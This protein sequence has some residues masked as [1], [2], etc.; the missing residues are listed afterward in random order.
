MK[1]L[2]TLLIVIT[3]AV[4]GLTACDTSD[5]PATTK[6]VYTMTMETPLGE[7][8]VTPAVGTHEYEE[9]VMVDLEAVPDSGWY[10]SQWEGEVQNNNA[11]S[12]RIKMDKNQTVRAVFTDQDPTIPATG[13]NLSVKVVDLQEMPISGVEVSFA[14]VDIDDFT[15][16]T[17]GDGYVV[18]SNSEITAMSRDAISEERLDERRVRGADE[19]SILEFEFSLLGDVT[20]TPS[21]ENWAFAP[22]SATVNQADAGS[23]I[24]FVGTDLLDPSYQLGG[25]VED[26]HGKGVVGAQVLLTG[27]DFDESTLGEIITDSDG[28]WGPVVVEGTVD[29]TAAKDH[30]TFTPITVQTGD[31]NLVISGEIF[32]DAVK[33]PLVTPGTISLAQSTEVT[34]NVEVD[35]NQAFLALLE[36]EHA[37][38]VS[39]YR[40][41]NSNNWE[42]IDNLY[43]DGDYINHGDDIAGDRIYSNIIDFYEEEA[44]NI[45]LKIVVN[46]AE[47]HV[48]E[49]KFHLEAASVAEDIEGK[50]LSIHEEA[51]S[52]LNEILLADPS[53]TAAESLNLL[54]NKLLDKEEITSIVQNN[55]LLQLD[56]EFIEPGDNFT[57]VSFIMVEET[58]E[59][60][61]F[62][63]GGNGERRTAPATSPSGQT[64]GKPI[65]FQYTPLNEELEFIGSRN[66]L[67]WAPFAEE[68]SPWDET[69]GVQ[70]RFNASE[71]GFD[72]SVYQNFAADVNSLRRINDYGMVILATHGTGGRW[73]ATGEVVLDDNKYSLD[74]TGGRMA[75]WQNMMTVEA[76]GVTSKMP[77]YA[78]NDN[79]FN[80]HISGSFSNSVIVNNSCESLITDRLWNTF[81]ALGAGAYYGYDAIVTSRFAVEQVYELVEGMRNGMIT[82][83]EAY[84]GK[85][86]PYSGH[87]ARWLMRGNEDLVFPAGLINGSFEDGLT[88][89]LRDGDG[90]AISALSFLEPT[91]GNV[92]GIIS[93]GL[94]RTVRHGSLQQTFRVDDEAEK[95][96]FDYNYLSEEFLEWI[97][98][99]YQDPFQV[100]IESESGTEVILYLTVDGIAA[101]YGAS[102]CASHT[103]PAFECIKASNSGSLIP[104]SPYITFDMGDVWMTGWQPFAYDISHYQGEVI[105]LKFMAEDEGDTAYDTAV[106]LDNIRIED[107][108]VTEEEFIL[109]I[110]KT[111]D[112]ET[113]PV[114]GSYS[115]PAGTMVDISALPAG[116]AEFYTWH[117]SSVTD[118]EALETTVLMD[119]HKTVTAVFLSPQPS[120]SFVYW[121]FD[122]DL[123][124]SEAGQEQTLN[125]EYYVNLGDVNHYFTATLLN[126][127][128]LEETTYSNFISESGYY[129][130]EL[131]YT[132]PEVDDPAEAVHVVQELELSG[133]MTASSVPEANADTST[134]YFT[135]G[136]IAE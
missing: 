8:T 6:S 129:E 1:K 40:K 2:L 47:N 23:T 110:N 33:K 56:Y 63:R 41:T 86:D 109:T 121:V 11:A 17:D 112:G 103:K 104:V 62:L 44:Q 49:V 85:N 87:N 46:T 114:P 122:V 136:F 105:T 82:T 34:F 130:G 126:Y 35:I 123:P 72:Y 58:E 119:G 59:D 127:D 27:D 81:S 95:L 48:I 74:L 12:T 70:D 55:N 16:V 99:V 77:V 116:G 19:Q 25:T 131:S 60:A 10:F 107:T 106:L 20:I 117:G 69:E 115:Y 66:I 52:E 73:L 64:T 37:T 18:L 57:A 39:L 13:Y 88:A 26:I 84:Q 102:Y 75:I 128:T 38:P 51:E 5:S 118:A 91:D 133:Q 4:F 76:G 125:F 28:N 31:L 15:R 120:T 29:I 43:D 79:W 61:G 21:L 14:G 98:S 22:T 80:H 30:W 67:I 111:G 83:G 101:D 53:L 124:V 135:V 93:S 50:I 9:D 97:G 94:G 100:S 113:Q 71:L 36:S 3:L 7:G 68:F 45:P 108:A 90:R 96:Y 134:V 54:K 78:V 89:W 92:M 42:F 24:E 132:A 32:K 65:S